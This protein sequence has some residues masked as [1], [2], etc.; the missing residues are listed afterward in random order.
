MTDR[1]HFG[2]NEDRYVQVRIWVDGIG[3]VTYVD[4]KTEANTAVEVKVTRGGN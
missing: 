2:A 1:L 3:W 4:T